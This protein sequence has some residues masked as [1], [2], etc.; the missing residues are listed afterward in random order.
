MSQHKDS[1]DITRLSS[2]S[3]VCCLLWLVSGFHTCDVD[4]GGSVATAAL[5]LHYP[6][7]ATPEGKGK[8]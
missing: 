4:I 1:E 6:R 7:L 3:G 2:V 5:G 8:P